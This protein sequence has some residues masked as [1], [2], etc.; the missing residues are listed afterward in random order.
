M[1]NKLT[2]PYLMIGKPEDRADLLYAARFSAPDDVVFLQGR[3]TAF[4]VV[5]PMEYGRARK[6]TRRG[7]CVVS[8]SELILPKETPATV[9]DWALALLRRER[10]KRCAVPGWMPVASVRALEGAGIRL[11]VD[12]LCF[13]AR[14]AVK[15]ADE[16]AMI[17]RAQQAAVCGYRAARRAIATASIGRNGL[18]RLNGRLLTSEGLR[19]LIETELLRHGCTAAGGTITS[20]GPDSADPHQHGAGPLCAGSPIVL[21]IFPRDA[22]T[23]YWGDLTRTLVKGDIPPRIMAM[24]EAVCA[25]RRTALKMIAPG[26]MGS[27]IHAAVHAVFEARGFHTSLAGKKPCGFIHSTGHGVGLDIHESPRISIRGGPL[28]EGNVITIEPGLY[29]PD[30]G[31]VRIEDTVAVTRQGRLVLASAPIGLVP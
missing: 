6:Q 10:V 24:Y 25:A 14:R 19:T 17:R 3:S 13:T 11:G 31:G 20:C 7:V 29:Y 16:M 26:I 21:D 9:T 5:P 1:K 15:S 23:G 22:R 12:D 2:A 28:E 30:L 8:S 4:L 27:E 18:L